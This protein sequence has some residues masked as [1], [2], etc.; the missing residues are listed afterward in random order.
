MIKPYIFVNLV[1]VNRVS[2]SKYSREVSYP[3]LVCSKDGSILELKNLD[4]FP[5][6]QQITITISILNDKTARLSERSR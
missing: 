6:Q 2:F 5:C 3:S 4:V 1:H